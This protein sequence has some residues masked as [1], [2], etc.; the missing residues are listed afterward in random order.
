MVAELQAEME[1]G[2]ELLE[3]LRA[4]CVERPPLDRIIG[5]GGIETLDGLLDALERNAYVRDVGFTQNE[6]LVA[7][8]APFLDEIPSMYEGLYRVVSHADVR[9]AL[10]APDSPCVA[11]ESRRFGVMN[12]ALLT[13]RLANA[14]LAAYPE[15]FALYEK[16]PI[17]KVVLKDDEA[18]LDAGLHTVEA[19]RVVL[20]TNGF[21]HLTILNVSGLDIDTKFHHAVSGKVGF[22][23][24]HVYAEH[25]PAGSWWYFGFPEF[26]LTHDVPEGKRIDPFFYLSRRPQYQHDDQTLLVMGGPELSLPD[27]AV[28]DPAMPYP[29]E[30]RD[31]LDN[32]YCRLYGPDAIKWWALDTKSPE[33]F[34]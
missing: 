7:D 10:E 27:R 33:L 31:M 13:E 3:E 18:L 2:W 23:N 21:E 22:M 8:V 16:T 14:L 20:C 12:S 11:A 19:E 6:V 34:E 1:S 30:A 4:F 5:H 17:N 24:G 9:D 32:I 25:R 29:Q 15:R 26:K 28:Y